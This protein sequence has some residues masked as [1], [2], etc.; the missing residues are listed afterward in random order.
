MSG[1]N[2]LLLL[3]FAGVAI[4]F[5]SSMSF[6]HNSSVTP[7]SRAG[8]SVDVRD[9]DDGSGTVIGQLDQ[10][11]MRPLVSDTEFHYEIRF[12][13]GVTGFKDFGIESLLSSS[14]HG[15]TPVLNTT[16]VTSV[17]PTRARERLRRR[18]QLEW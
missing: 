5:F 4:L 13:P 11:E 2:R 3:A 16:C 1:R 6:G 7:S 9:Q 17:S 15:N 12:A 10:G 18:G 14:R 8:A